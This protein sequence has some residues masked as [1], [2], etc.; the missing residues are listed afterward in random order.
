[1]FPEGGAVLPAGAAQPVAE[2]QLEPIWPAVVG[3]HV[4][5]VQK[6]LHSVVL[7]LLLAHRVTK[8]TKQAVGETVM[9]SK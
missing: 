9:C 4:S 6:P 3:L 5:R 8:H 1:M 7:L 2:A